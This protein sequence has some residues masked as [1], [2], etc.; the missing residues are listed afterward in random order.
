MGEQVDALC[1]E[2]AL[3]AVASHYATLANEAANKKR[4]FIDFLESVL[5][6]VASLREERRRKTLRRLAAFPS[7]KGHPNFP[8]CGH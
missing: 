6:E 5:A 4:S 3:T 1:T 2:L 7:V 8:G